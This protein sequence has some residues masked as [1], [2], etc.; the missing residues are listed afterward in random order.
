MD[1]K[2]EGSDS[3]LPVEERRVRLDEKRL[4]LDNSFAKKWLPTL[5]T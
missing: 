5:V 1:P 3:Q 2:N 4:I